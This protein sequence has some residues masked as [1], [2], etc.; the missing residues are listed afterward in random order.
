MKKATKNG[1]SKPPKPPAKIK[2]KNKFFAD[3]KIEIN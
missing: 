3:L 2:V 1:K